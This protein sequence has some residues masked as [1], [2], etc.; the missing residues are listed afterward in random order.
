MSGN[1]KTIC[2][3]LGGLVLAFAAA[4]VMAQ[5]TWRGILVAPEIMCSPYHSDDYSYNRSMIMGEKWRHVG[6][7]FSPYDNKV[8]DPKDVDVEHR[9]S[10]HQAHVSGMCARPMQDR[11]GFAHDMSN[12]TMAESN[13]NRVDKSDKDA[14]EWSPRKNRCHFAV[15]VMITK[16]TWG[17][18]VDPAERDAL[19][20]MVQECGT[21]VSLSNCKHQGV[22]EHGVPGKIAA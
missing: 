12:I 22:R 9:V 18:S 6:A 15:S 2:I 8:Y 11:V 7:V 4:H 21:L 16:C 3:L 14:S 10:R 19:E 17:L 5:G 13:L 1:E 20:E